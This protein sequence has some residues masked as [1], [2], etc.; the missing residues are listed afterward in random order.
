VKARI[1][2]I[3]TV[4]QAQN[5]IDPVAEY[6][7]ALGASVTGGYVYRGNSIPAL[8][9]R[10]VFADFVS[11]R[12]W[13]IARDT[14]PTLQVSSGFDSGLSVASFGQ[15]IDGEMFV[16]HYG[17]TLHRLV[18]GAG[19]STGG[20]I[21]TQLSA[22]GC[23]NPSNATQPASGLIP[24]APNAPF[25]SDGS[26]KA[27]FLALPNGQNIT[28]GADGDWDFPNGS[29]LVKNFAIGTRLVETR[30]FMRHTNGN[31]GGYTY[32]WNGG[33]TDATRVVGGKTVQVAG[34]SWIFPSESQ[35]FACHTQASGRSLG[36]ETAQLNGNL[37]YPAT[38]R[39]AN[40]IVT[41]NA[42]NTS[43]P[44]DHGDAGIAAVD[45]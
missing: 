17:G 15:G 6:G 14:P 27:R 2:S 8:A 11:G 42:I 16:V 21:P 35:C 34:Q 36:L 12:I 25:W 7:R 39:T 41:L 26:T 19:G 31:W 24:Y 13:H 4:V 44:A 3:P 20:T 28:V 43:E 33:G 23:V 9:G 22:T 29:V 30:L 38:N 5:L 1:R 18:A 10:Y 40:Q 37:L 45:A 32:E